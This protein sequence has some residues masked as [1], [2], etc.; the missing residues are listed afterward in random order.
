MK[1]KIVL[2]Q[3][4]FT[5]LSSSKLRPALVLHEGKRDVVVA[6]VPSRLPVEKCLTDIAIDEG[7]KDFKGTGLKVSSVIKLDKV[8]TLEKHLVRGEIGEIGEI[9]RKEVSRKVIE[10]LVF[11]RK[12]WLNLIC[13]G[14]GFSVSRL[15]S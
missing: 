12:K 3:F 11:F 15:C 13:A 7:S 8:A 9:T 6:F 1:G 4:P 10:A 2:V 14:P 5:D